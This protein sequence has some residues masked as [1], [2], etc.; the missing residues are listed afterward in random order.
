MEVDLR[1]EDGELAGADSLNGCWRHVAVAYSLAS[2]NRGRW[3]VFLDGRSLGTADNAVVPEAV[4]GFKGRYG[5]G[6]QTGYTSFD[7]MLDCWRV[8]DGVLDPTDFLYTSPKGMTILF[9]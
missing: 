2:G 1:E 4:D 3:E 5:I 6:A 9:R 7:G 8:S